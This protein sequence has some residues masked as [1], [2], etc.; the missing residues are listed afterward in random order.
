MLNVSDIII[1]QKMA[2]VEYFFYRKQIWFWPECNTPRVY[3]IVCSTVL[4]LPSAQF[5]TFL[6]ITISNQIKQVQPQDGDSLSLAFVAGSPSQISVVQR[7][8]YVCNEEIA[9]E[10]QRKSRTEHSRI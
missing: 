9:K 1:S 6:L 4:F 5:E 2:V 8:T 7:R 10:L 3:R